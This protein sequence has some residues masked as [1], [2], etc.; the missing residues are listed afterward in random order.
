MGMW[1][2]RI[3]CTAHG[4]R[5]LESLDEAVREAR[6]VRRYYTRQ[7]SLHGHCFYMG[8]C[9]PLGETERRIRDTS[10]YVIDA[11]RLAERDSVRKL[12]ALGAVVML[13]VLP[14]PVLRQLRVASGAGRGN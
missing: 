5:M 1:T 11:E 3:T 8:L 13:M 12:M 6:L 2:L 7:G 10:D 14:G 9:D 4:L